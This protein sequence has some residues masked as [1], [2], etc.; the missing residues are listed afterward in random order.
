MADDQFKKPK[1]EDV[2]RAD[3][4]GAKFPVKPKPWDYVKEAF[5]T[6]DTRAQ[7]NAI[8]KRKTGDT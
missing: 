2:F 4:S 3:N 8:R 5:Q 1:E 7:I 6:D